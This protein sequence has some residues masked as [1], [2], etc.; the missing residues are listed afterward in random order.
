[1]EEEDK[2]DRLLEATRK[3]CGAFSE[4]LVSVNPETTEV[5]GFV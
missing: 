4:L 1:M 3:L 5:G 2:G